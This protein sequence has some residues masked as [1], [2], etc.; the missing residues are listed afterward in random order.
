[1]FR[2]FPAEMCRLSMTSLFLCIL[3]MEGKTCNDNS[4]TNFNAEFS[5]SLY[6]AL[7]EK[8][9]SNNLIVS[10]ASISLSLRLLQLGARGNT[11]LQLERTTGYDINS[12]HR[13][14]TILWFCWVKG[15]CYLIIAFWDTKRR[16]SPFLA[17]PFWFVWI[18]IWNHD[19][20]QKSQALSF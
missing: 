15:D 6:Q 1:M 16:Q 4:A 10:P 11:L 19:P 2:A 7:A 9:N 5:I 8:D 3:T 14:C 17:P 18:L 13:H 12:E 20:L